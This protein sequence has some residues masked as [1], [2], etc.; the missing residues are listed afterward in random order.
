MLTC[1]AISAPATPSRNISILAYGEI[2]V[3]MPIE[4]Q[5]VKKIP[6]KRENIRAIIPKDGIAY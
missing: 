2:F 3:K 4:G 6:D 1:C 5:K